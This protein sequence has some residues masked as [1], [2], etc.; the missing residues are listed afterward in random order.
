M[1]KVISGEELVENWKAANFPP[2]PRDEEWE[3]LK[4]RVCEKGDPLNPILLASGG[5]IEVEQFG[6]IGWLDKVEM[7]KDCEAEGSHFLQC[8]LLEARETGTG[9]FGEWLENVKKFCM[10][11]Y[12][13]HFALHNITN[14]KLYRYCM[15]HNVYVSAEGG[16]LCH[17]KE[18]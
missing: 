12:G 8:S 1:T 11:E 4:H 10:D 2:V 18:G 13:M 16:M 5:E 3:N 15:N 6:I 17:V 14:Q 9:R 7:H